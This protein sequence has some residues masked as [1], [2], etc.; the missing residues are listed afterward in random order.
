MEYLMFF[1]EKYIDLARKFCLLGADDK[2]L[3]ELF[4]VGVATIRKWIAEE[5]EFR[6][7]VLEGR[8]RADAEVVHSLYRRAVGFSRRTV[9]T[10][11]RDSPKGPTITRVFSRTYYPPD[12]NAAMFWLKNRRKDQWGSSD[13]EK[14]EFPISFTLNLGNDRDPQSKLSPPVDVSEAGSRDLQFEQDES[15]R[16]GDEDGQDSRVYRMADRTDPPPRSRR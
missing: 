12:V 3:A 8:D 16:G 11:H 9:T 15:D 7:A 10:T 4:N 6:E 13:E 1:D 2:Q 5:D 14:N